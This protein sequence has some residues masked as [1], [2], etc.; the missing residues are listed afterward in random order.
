MS[1]WANYAADCLLDSDTLDVPQCAPQWRY[2]AACEWQRSSF[3]SLA[4]NSFPVLR[5]AASPK[6]PTCCCLH[7]C[8][9]YGVHLQDAPYRFLL[10]LHLPL[11]SLL[12]SPMHLCS[13]GEVKGLWDVCWDIHELTLITSAVLRYKVICQPLTII[14]TTVLCMQAC[15]E[16]M[17]ALGHYVCWG[18]SPLPFH[19]IYKDITDIFAGSWALSPSQ[20]SLLTFPPTISPVCVSTKTKNA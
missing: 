15:F 7:P 4:I 6:P 10:G 2:F 12:L 14:N 13:G 17:G 19:F 9:W 5:L 11:C 16:K 3:S 18:S 8:P 20:L 1:E